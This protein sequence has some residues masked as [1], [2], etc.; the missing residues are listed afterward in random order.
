MQ[1]HLSNNNKLSGPQVSKE[2]VNNCDNINYTVKG[3]RNQML[4]LDEFKEFFKECSDR[5]TS[6]TLGKEIFWSKRSHKKQSSRILESKNK[7][8]AIWKV[9]S[10]TQKF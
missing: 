3:I 7:S 2:M 1:N 6:Q 8:S 9:S 5:R 4:K 10:Q